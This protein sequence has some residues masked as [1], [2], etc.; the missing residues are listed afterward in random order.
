MGIIMNKLMGF[1]ELKQ[2]S[3]P[4]IPWQE[5]TGNNTFDETKLWT[6]RT[7]VLQGDDLNLPRYVGVTGSEAVKYAEELYEVFETEGMVIYYPFFIAEKSGT[8]NVFKDKVVVEAVKDDLWNLVTYSDREVTIIQT[9]NE[10]QIL[11]NETF[12]SDEELN[13]ILQYIPKIR[14]MFRDHLTEGE[15]VLLEWSYAYDSDP[16][17]NKMGNKYLV[18]YEARTL[19]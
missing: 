5:Y 10:C 14:L 11:G 8:L 12:L 15:S 9:E 7:A 19:S 4:S 2:S 6:I 1:F 16:D 13:D 18:F 17:K 3:L